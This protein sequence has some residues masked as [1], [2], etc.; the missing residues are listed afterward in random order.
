MP[1]IATPNVKGVRWSYPD[2]I[3]N[4][5]KQLEPKI[6]SDL[7]ENKIDPNDPN[8]L[9]KTS[10]RDG[11]DGLGDVAIHKEIS[12]RFLPDKAFRFSF[13]IFKIEAIVGNSEPVEIFVED[14]PY[15]VRTNR[16]LLKAICD[17]NQRASN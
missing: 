12:D 7:I 2:A 4:T 17:E 14:K 9:L 6:V 3:A 11:A 16:P 10:I 5:L 1:E 15:S 13:C 8:I